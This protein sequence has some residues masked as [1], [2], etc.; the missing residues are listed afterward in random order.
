MVLAGEAQRNAA[1]HVWTQLPPPPFTRPF[2][3]VYN[4]LM[5][6]IGRP[7]M[8]IVNPEF[9]T[10][11]KRCEHEEEICKVL[12]C[13]AALHT[14]G[15]KDTGAGVAGHCGGAGHFKLGCCAHAAV[16]L[17][18]LQGGGRRQRG[19]RLPERSGSA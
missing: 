7:D 5:R 17:A 3:A 9:S 16:C 1:T 8:G 19:I 10:D 2:L 4:R 6:A 11:A 12:L 14:L 13:R 15:Q 18:E